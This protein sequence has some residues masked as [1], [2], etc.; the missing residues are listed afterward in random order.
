MHLEADGEAAFT[1]EDRG[2][3]RRGFCV[4]GASRAHAWRVGGGR[5]SHLAE[6]PGSSA[7]PTAS[8]RLPSLRFQCGPHA[9][10]RAFWTCAGRNRAHGLASRDGAGKGFAYVRTARATEL[11]PK[12]GGL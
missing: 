1:A 12:P 4:R 6:A 7:G 8:A 2:T 3:E 10:Q 5:S 11:G 9:A